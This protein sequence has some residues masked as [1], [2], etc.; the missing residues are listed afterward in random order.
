MKIFVGT[1]HAGF[2]LKEKLIPYLI[3]LGYEV[4]DLGAHEYNEGD[5]YPDF[6]IPVAREVS[7]HPNDVKGIVLGGTGEGEAMCANR[8]KNVRATTFYGE[9]KSIAEAGES[10]VKLSREHNNANILSLGARFITEVQMMKAV[11]EW[12][13]TSFSGEERHVRRIY[14]M[15]HI[16][17]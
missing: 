2:E 9:V 11:S 12:L 6:T 3:S 7:L 16:H 5:D 15:D 8:F 10:L 17:E 4:E 1:D 13:E 14:K